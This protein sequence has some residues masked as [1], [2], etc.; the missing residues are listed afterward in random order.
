MIMILAL[1]LCLGIMPAALAEDAQPQGENLLLNSGFEELDASGFPIDWM[2]GMYT[3][4]DGTTVMETVTGTAHSGSN[5]VRLRSFSEND[6]RYEQV[7][8]CQPQTLYKLSGWARVQ[9]VPE[10][11]GANLSVG[12]G[13]AM[14]DSLSGTSAEGEWTYLEIYGM[15]GPEQYTMT[16]MARL[17]FYGST[18]TGTAWFDDLCL[19]RVDGVPKDAPFGLFYQEQT[20][21][22]VEEETEVVR[23]YTP[24]VIGVALAFAALA[25][26][27]IGMRERGRLPALASE[28]GEVPVLIAMLAVAFIARL[29]MAAMIPGYPNDI[30][31]WQG[32]G[33]RM[34][35][36]GPW[37]FYASGEFCD[38]P[39]AYMYVLALL[40]GLRALTGASGG[41]AQLI[42]KLP[43]M[44]CD[45]AGALLIYKW[46]KREGGNGGMALWL[47]AF[48]AFNPATICDS[49]AWGQ[50][51]SVFTLMIVG[52]VYLCVRGS[53]QWGLPL[54]IVSA[55]VKPQT[56]MLGPIALVVLLTEIFRAKGGE[57]GIMLKKVGIGLAISVGAA[58]LIVVPFWGGQNWDWLIGKYTE[59]LSSYS[60]ATVNAMNMYALFG[61]NWQLADSMVMGMPAKVWGY[62]FM[63]VAIAYSAFVYIKAKDRR[64][65][66]LACA[67]LVMVLFTFSTKMHE[68]YAFPAIMLLL[69]GYVLMKDK[70]LLIMSALISVTQFINMALVLQSQHLQ[71]T[72]Q[73]I[74]S[75]TALGNIAL[76]AW[77]CFAAWDI[78]VRGRHSEFKGE[79]VES[80]P[81]P[82]GE[83]MLS[84]REDMVRRLTGKSD[85]KLGMKAVD[86]AV[87]GAI[88]VAYSVVAFTNLGTMSAPQTEW[89]SSTP[90]ETVTIDL[91][92][93]RTFDF[94]Y[95][96]GICDST[97]TVEF[98]LDGINW[99]E[100]G[101][102]DYRQGKM[103]QWL[104]YRPT[105]LSDDG[106]Y[107]PL[108]N[109][110]PRNTARY[111]RLTF[112]SVGFKMR[113][114][115][116]L[117]EN[118]QC[119]P[120]ASIECAGGD[121]ETGD[122]PAKMIDEQSTVPAKPS[123]YNSMY[124]DEIYHAR[125]AYEHLNGLHAYEWTHPPLGK[126]L[127]MLGIAMFGM[128]PFGWR[129]MGA[130]TGVMMVPVMYLLT[131]QLFKRRDLSIFTTMLMAL[132]FMHFTQTRI[133]T[134]DSY[135]VFFIMVMYLFM[136]RYMQM[137]FFRDGLKKTLTPLALCGLFMGI[138]CACKWI[139]IYAAAGLAVLFFATMF[140]RYNEYRFARERLSR[141][142]RM[143]DELKPYVFAR[144]NFVK[145]LMITLA[146]CCVLFIAVP[147]V[148]Y[149][150]SYYWQLT[151]DHNF[152]IKG[153]VDVQKSMLSYH[154]GLSGDTHPFRAQ[155][156]TWPLITKPMYYYS[157]R[158]FMPEGM[159]S[160]IWCMGNPAVWWPML[161]GMLFTIGMSVRE[162]FRD[163]DKL[164]VI[165]SFLAQYLPWVLVP[166]SMFIYHYFASI[167]FM[168]LSMC[169]MIKHLERR[170]PRSTKGIAIGIVVASAVLF[171]LFYPVISGAPCSQALVDML[172]KL[173]PWHIY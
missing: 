83:D 85:Y 124:F 165:V 33:N 159:Q 36:L 64:A 19:E 18:V 144:D 41:M 164:I 116:F 21:E 55:L 114:V 123:Y 87:L 67:V 172:D 23:S 100:P 53:W 107:T 39:P 17:G 117:D 51:D 142:K 71:S 50:I 57:R 60:Y 90:G 101:T 155:W 149:Y 26:V 84:K 118:G 45:M 34:N 173:G 38:Y 58:A 93:E 48:Y 4:D 52:A 73:L 1:I 113:E 154:S 3:W 46:M 16:I 122:D 138:G 125:T 97:F 136:F 143:T 111:A 112:N 153:V 72:E 61:L 80:R 162:K 157:G 132:D 156:Y 146:L 43:A 49:A 20:A 54:Y 140:M 95:Y 169:F 158:E 147:L 150:L 121:I 92:E 152:T 129:F 108:V 27:L 81:K 128:T 148:I 145:Y 65:M 10:G 160:I 25:L 63:A 13:F 75:L 66:P 68:R 6:A 44:L 166:R 134:I 109:G 82:G 15:T 37:G 2:Q 78:C 88:T 130:L 5:S 99:T 105:M 8:A 42:V 28:R 104:W 40:D 131:K 24:L 171:A 62:I 126:V 163:R 161:L 106:T 151:P 89:R 22:V 119:Y 7:V 31:C 115:G 91:G 133:A 69:L 98:S 30:A 35:T 96:G 103:F 94:T 86:W 32:W 120:I 11:I 14:S 102:A 56:L 127:M 110:Y 76:T 168:I 135:G 70:R 59:T 170:Y 29:V 79:R 167:P 47:A 139:D 9:D 137:S 74:N 12:E 77:L 141:E